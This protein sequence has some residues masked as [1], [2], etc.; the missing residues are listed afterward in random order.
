LA[1]AESRIMK[2]PRTLLVACLQL[3][4]AAVLL[5]P[6]LWLYEASFRSSQD[7]QGGGLL[8]ASLSLDNY[9]HL[10]SQ[11]V[12]LA[13]LRN[14]FLVASFSAIVTTAMALAA[15]YAVSRFRFRG[16]GVV[17]GVVLLTQVVPGIV[18]IVPIVVAMRLLGLADTLQGVAIVHLMLALPIAFWLLRNF[19]DELPRE[20]EEAAFLDGCGQV[21][22]LRYIVLPLLRPAIVA[23]GSFAF[24]LSWGE[25]MVALSLLTS[26]DVK[27]LPLAMQTLFQLHGV[28]LGLVASAGVIVSLPV[29]VLFLLVQGQ[30]IA[31][32]ASGGV[33]G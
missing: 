33:K 27:T 13:G 9:V 2:A 14:S 31:G 20:I 24:I 30:L 15:A 5:F 25:Y 28:D 10:F 8:P 1:I 19:I 23:V 17:I 29:A 18:V 21:S 32:L 12:M 11:P 3:L 6:I 7:I 26:E 4:V 16:R 22:V